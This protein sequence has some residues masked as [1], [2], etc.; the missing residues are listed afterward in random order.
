MQPNYESIWWGYIY[1]QMM[2][3]DLSDQVETTLQFYQT[4]LQGVSGPVLE[5]ACGTGLPIRQ[6]II[7]AIDL[8]NQL[9]LDQCYIGYEGST[10]D[11]PMNGRLIF[12]EE[13]QLLLRLA[14][15]SRWEAY[16]TPEGAPLQIGLEEVHSY[17]V[18]WK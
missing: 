2:L 12:K 17:W 8:D 9:T 16:S 15:F 7:G 3:T 11:F 5:C 18:V 14:G 4:Q 6:R 10:V 13:L 1:E